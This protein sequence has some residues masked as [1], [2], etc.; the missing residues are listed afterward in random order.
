MRYTRYVLDNFATV[1]DAIEGLKGLRAI[2]DAICK[3][4][5]I[6]DGQVRLDQ[7]NTILAMISTCVSYLAHVVGPRLG[8]PHGA[9]GRDGR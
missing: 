9:R 4:V 8:S 3:D 5:P 6:T 1:A 7:T 2:R